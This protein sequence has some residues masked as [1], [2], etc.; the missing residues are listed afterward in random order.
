MSDNN[1]FNTFFNK[2]KV[3]SHIQS[4]PIAHQH[5][6]NTKY[7]TRFNYRPTDRVGNQGNNLSVI[8]Y[9]WQT[10]TIPRL[11][12]IGGGVHVN[13]PRLTMTDANRNWNT[14][15]NR[16]DDIRYDENSLRRYVGQEWG[17]RQDPNP[18]NPRAGY[19]NVLQAA[20]NTQ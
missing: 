17:R 10:P 18:G 19:V 16:S 11:N 9:Q 7:V 4:D 20:G 2:N 12:P 14:N 5:V 3:W 13:R 6:W 1:F 15:T 8:P